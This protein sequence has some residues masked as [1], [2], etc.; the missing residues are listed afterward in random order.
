MT[1]AWCHIHSLLWQMSRPTPQLPPTP[2]SV[3]MRNSPTRLTSQVC[4]QIL[5]VRTIWTF[6]GS[7][8][9]SVWLFDGF[10]PEV[11]A[12][13]RYQLGSGERGDSHHDPVVTVNHTVTRGHHLLTRIISAI[14]KSLK[15]QLVRRILICFN[16]QPITRILW[17]YTQHS[18]SSHPITRL[19]VIKGSLNSHQ[20]HRMRHTFFLLLMFLLFIYIF[21]YTHMLLC[22]SIWNVLEMCFHFVFEIK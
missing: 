2:L 5:W 14:I 13:C 20:S 8:F 22:H 7:V 6:L 16:F 15:L 19:N 1:K 17:L 11:C 18:F 21:S 12:C 9:T 10:Y 3:P 4:F